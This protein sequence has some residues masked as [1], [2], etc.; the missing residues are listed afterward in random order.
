MRATPLKQATPPAPRACPCVR[1]P[2]PPPAP[3]QVELL[4]RSHGKT[5]HK[6]RGFTDTSAR[7]SKFKTKEG[8]ELTVE[9]YFA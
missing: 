3:W 8:K 1:S 7:K 9:G 4:H 6:I 2:R 5:R